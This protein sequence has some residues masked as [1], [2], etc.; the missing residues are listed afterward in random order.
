[1]LVL[2]TKLWL[3]KLPTAAQQAQAVKQRSW[4]EALGRL[5]GARPRT[6][7]LCALLLFVGALPLLSRVGL[8]KNL[9]TMDMGGMPPALTQTEISR[10]FG[11]HQRFLVVLLKDSDGERALPQGLDARGGTHCTKQR[12]SP[13][14]S[15]VRRESPAAR[16]VSRS[17]AFL[18]FL[19]PDRRRSRR[20]TLY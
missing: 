12:E 20:L 14:L 5:S 4:L 18:T 13:T 15:A 16:A 11:E 10:R 8:G 7:L 1:M 3:G 2:P 17:I 9:L 19:T 6:V